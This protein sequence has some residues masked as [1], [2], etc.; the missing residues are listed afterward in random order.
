MARG[1]VP[2]PIETSSICSSPVAQAR[3]YGSRV[4]IRKSWNAGLLY[5]VTPPS[6]KTND[7]PP[8]MS[9]TSGGKYVGAAVLARTSCQSGRS[10]LPELARSGRLYFA[11]GCWRAATASRWSRCA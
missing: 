11:P 3:L 9:I 10:R 7:L 4:A 8:P 6:T 1:F 2:V 5:I